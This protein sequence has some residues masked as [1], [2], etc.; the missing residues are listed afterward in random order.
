MLEVRDRI[1]GGEDDRNNRVR[2]K[3]LGS[4]WGKK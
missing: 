2:E 4:R 1:E 3:G